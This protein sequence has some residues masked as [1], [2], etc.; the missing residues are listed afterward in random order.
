MTNEER[1][2]YGMVAALLTAAQVRYGEQWPAME[3][4]VTSMLI[5]ALGTD[6]RHDVRRA[7]T[8]DDFWAACDVVRN[9]VCA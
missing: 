7:T 8:S 3:P 6:S 1:V 9:F 5:A 4:E 2:V